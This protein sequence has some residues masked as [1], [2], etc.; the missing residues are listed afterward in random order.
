[1]NLIFSSKLE[2][3][4]LWTSSCTRSNRAF[5]ENLGHE[6]CRHETIRRTLLSSIF[7][8]FCMSQNIKKLS[9]SMNPV[10]S[11]FFGIWN[12]E[13]AVVLDLVLC[14]FSMYSTHPTSCRTWWRKYHFKE[15]GMYS[16]L[17]QKAVALY[18]Y[19]TAF[20][21]EQLCL[22]LQIPKTAAFINFL[23]PTDGA[24]AHFPYTTH[25]ISLSEAWHLYAHSLQKMSY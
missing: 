21:E 20:L 19:S 2:Y 6:F 13:Q 10:L 24:S 8:M 4:T 16:I 18:R 25:S 23:F 5:F 22:N 12:I 3:S 14:R 7:R 1:M 9:K 15:S 11:T 17:S